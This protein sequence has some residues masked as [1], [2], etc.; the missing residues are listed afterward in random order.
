MDDYVLNGINRI[1]FSYKD[2]KLTKHNSFN[3]SDLENNIGSYK[4]INSIRSI[5]DNYNINKKFK[6][7]LIRKINAKK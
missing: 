6:S 1:T 3:E 4:V 2:Y 7:K 5:E